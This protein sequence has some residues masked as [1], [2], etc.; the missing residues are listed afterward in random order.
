MHT[1]Y[2][3]S[4]DAYLMVVTRA[5]NSVTLRKP[6]EVKEEVK[7]DETTEAEGGEDEEG[8]EE[9]AE[10]EVAEEAAPEEEEEEEIIELT[11]K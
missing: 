2:K 9:D 5:V 1:F 3:Y 7:V 4:L 10:D 8:D 6:K 11:G